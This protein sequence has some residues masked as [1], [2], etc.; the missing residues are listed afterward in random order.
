MKKVLLSRFTAVLLTMVMTLSVATITAGAADMESK[1]GEFFAY[2]FSPKD[3][4]LENIK[5]SYKIPYE[6]FN[7]EGVKVAAKKTALELEAMPEGKRCLDLNYI[8]R[9]ITQESENYLWW[10]KGT[11]KI[12]KMMDE[13]FK[14]LK[15]NGGQLDYVIDDFEY[16]MSMWA[17]PEKAQTLPQIIADPRYEKEIRPLLVEAGFE[18]YPVSK[19]KTELEYLA[20]FTQSNAYNVWNG[21]MRE[22]VKAYYNKAITEPLHKYYPDVKSSNYAMVAAT[23]EEKVVYDLNGHKIY[24]GGASSTVG[25]THSSPELYGR[26]NQLCQKGR[27]PAGYPYEVFQNNPYNSALFALVCTSDAVIGTDGGKIMP[28]VGFKGWEESGYSNTDYYDEVVYH[29][30]LLNPDPFLLFNMNG[31]SGDE[32]YFN[33]L[34]EELNSIVGTGRRKTLLND[35]YKWDQRYILTGMELE[36][37]NIWRIT[38]DLYTPGITMENFICDKKNMIFQIGNQVIDFPEG[39]KFLETESDLKY[40]YWVTTP[41]GTRPTE[42]RVDGI[43]IPA[44]PVMDENRQP[45]GY[46]VDKTYKKYDPNAQIK[47]PE[48]SEDNKEDSQSPTTPSVDASISGHWAERA[49]NKA[50]KDGLIVGSDKG[51]EPDRNVTK[52]ELIT[53]MMRANGI[54]NNQSAGPQWYSAAANKAL[55]LGWTGYLGDIEYDINRAAS[56]GIIANAMDLSNVALDGKT[57]TDDAQINETGYLGAVRGCVSLGIITGYPDGSFRPLNTI[58]RAEAVVIIQRAFY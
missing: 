27:G 55:E 50:V 42:L 45:I 8:T 41:K 6:L 20:R 17:I 14:E 26:M 49:L 47:V 15:A 51:L 32:E 57:F 40:G 56:A 4:N 52:A 23:G 5:P 10:D 12:A 31:K 2:L 46:T 28:W 21:V 48:V 58:T 3:E 7:V 43:E 54:Q 25:G 30:G 37:K 36:D 24:Q 13:F 34:L 19:G 11:E 38:P 53:M 29:L 16:G 9:K 35:Q 39:S 22:R 18:F 33:N 44:E 1:E